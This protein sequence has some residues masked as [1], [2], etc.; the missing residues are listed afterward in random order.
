MKKNKQ[1]TSQGSKDTAICI[2][3]KKHCIKQFFKSVSPAP[4][5]FLKAM[6]ILSI[7]EK[8]LKFN[9]NSSADKAIAPA[10]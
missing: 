4:S 3:L 10:E 5:L 7:I 1:S 6:V 2:C 9:A 8:M